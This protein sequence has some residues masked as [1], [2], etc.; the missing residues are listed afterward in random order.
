MDVKVHYYKIYSV[1]RSLTEKLEKLEEVS[2]KLEKLEEVRSKLGKLE[3]V[4]STLE[5][6]AIF[7]VS[8]CMGT[9][10]L[11]FEGLSSELFAGSAARLGGRAWGARRSTRRR[12]W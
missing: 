6:L 1:N 10:R 8:D 7:E 11:T 4:R 5:Q 9:N 2:S 12:W 3:E